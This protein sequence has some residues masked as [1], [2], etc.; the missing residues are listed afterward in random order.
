VSLPGWLRID[1]AGVWRVVLGLALSLAAVGRAAAPGPSR[2]YVLQPAEVPPLRIDFND[3]FEKA[4]LAFAAEPKQPGKET[5][6]GLIPTV[7]ATPFLRN[8]TDG[9]L[10][11]NTDHTGDFAG[12]KL[13]TYRGVY[14]GRVI[15]SGLRV[16]TLRE[17]LEIPYTVDLFTDERPGAGWLHVL[18]GWEGGFEVDGRR[19]RLMIV[20]DLNAEIGKGDA[21][22]L[23]RMTDFGPGTLIPIRPVPTCLAL[24]GHVWN[25]AFDFKPDESGVIVEAAFTETNW[26][27]GTVTLD[28][29]ACSY[30]CLSHD[31]VTAVLDARAG[32]SPV[33][34][35]AYRIAGCLLEEIPGADPQPAFIRSDQTVRIQAGETRALPIGQP[36]RNTVEVTRDRNL[37]RLTYR[38]LGQAGEQYEYDAGRSQPRFT[39]W[40]GPVRIG[41]GTLPFG[42]RNGEPRSWRVPFYGIGTLRIVA[43]QDIGQLGPKEGPVVRVIC[44]AG[45]ALRSAVGWL[46][47]LLLLA[48]RKANHARQAWAVWIPPV[49]LWTAL[50]VAEGLL[51]SSLVFQDQQYIGS[52]L[53]DLLR[54]F[55]LSLAMLLAVA[56]RLDLR[57]RWLRVALAGLVLLLATSLQIAM[58]PWPF[59]EAGWWIVFFGVILVLF[60]LG[61]SLV[62]TILGRA[63][64]ARRFAK[65]YAGICLLAG[66]APCCALGILGFW[67]NHSAQLQSPRGPFRIAA[68][69]GAALSLPWLGYFAFVLLAMRFRLLSDRLSQAFGLK[70]LA[71]WLAKP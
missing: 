25:L 50:G 60:M 16:F 33:P 70:N 31:R 27:L 68:V 8:V 34:A 51:N 10:Y 53:A 63:I 47:L 24:D 1:T 65:W 32:A 9:A 7:P 38:L 19:W 61:H 55:T 44:P 13:E 56:D 6:R 42:W 59:L 3:N 62:K 30:V 22:Y 64:S 5:A 43:S 66:L 12:G 15:F 29:R 28:P 40:N 26:P 20:D 58:N 2:V 54:F 11:L 48:F 69:A 41:A 39:V 35:G 17:D 23:Q 45:D 46:A 57:W 71:P 21:L 14:D 36:L 52:S 49:V 37:L 4:P 18:S 67:L